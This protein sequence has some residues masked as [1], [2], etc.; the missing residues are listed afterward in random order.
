MTRTVLAIS[1]LGDAQVARVAV[2]LALQGVEVLRFHPADLPLNAR[3]SITI[4]PSAMQTVLSGPHL[5]EFR[6]EEVDVVWFGKPRPHHVPQDMP[7]AEA[8]FAMDECR[9]G[10]RAL[11][12]SLSC[13][14]VDH[15]SLS[16]RATNKP[17]QLAVARQVGLEIPRTVITNDPN[18]AKDFLETCHSGAV[19]KSLSRPFLTSPH[20]DAL[21]EKEDGRTLIFTTPLEKKHLAQL[22]LVGAAPC[23]FQEYVNKREELR[24]TV[25]GSRLFTAS[26]DSQAS[27]KTKHDWRQGDAPVRECDLPP[28]VADRC[29]EL[30]RRFGLTMATFDIVLTPD[31]RYVFLEINPTGRYGWIEDATSMPISEAVATLLATQAR[32]EVRRESV[33]GI[34]SWP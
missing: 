4:G 22:A 26:I 3:L 13:P 25:V 8:A 34:A 27:E 2:L 20:T 9:E 1:D 21:G 32:Q 30:C 11:I 28:V 31:E 29:L 19:Y 24:I 33:K 12:S 18:A 10:M 17:Y 14:W 7:R 6:P 15:P 16:S 23:L 5:R